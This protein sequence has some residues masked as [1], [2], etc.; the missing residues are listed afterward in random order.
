MQKI[1]PFLWFDNQA[2]EAMNFYTSI[3]KNAKAGNI[4]RYGE[5][6]PG[7]AGSVL[8]ASFELEGLQFTALNGGPLFKFTEA[9]SFHVACESQ[10]EVDYY[11]S[12]L[13]D[14]GQIQQCGWSKDKYGVSWQII[15]TALPKLL[16]DPDREKASR[17]MRAMLQMKKIDIAKLEQ[18]A[19]G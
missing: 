12:K 13:S 19:E 18:A 9:I 7:P 3:F 2:E 8:A 16:G 1:T 4:S 11:W 10:G 15:P 6:G 17:V 5:A 14:G